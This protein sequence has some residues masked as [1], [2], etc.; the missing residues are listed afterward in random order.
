MLHSFLSVRA[1]L[2]YCMWI[3]FISSAICLWSESDNLKE[4]LQSLCSFAEGAAISRPSESRFYKTLLP[5][6]EYPPPRRYALGGNRVKG[7][8][9]SQG[10]L[11]Q[12]QWGRFLGAERFYVSKDMRNIGGCWVY[13]NRKQHRT[14]QKLFFPGCHS[15]SPQAPVTVTGNPLCIKQFNGKKRTAFAKTQNSRNAFFHCRR[16][17]RRLW[18][19]SVGKFLVHLYDPRHPKVLE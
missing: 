5:M 16:K 14:L 2:K 3:L 17:R 11:P 1:N 12:W 6:L 15:Y 9:A 13:A 4:L 19:N 10:I 8:V 7:T 18:N